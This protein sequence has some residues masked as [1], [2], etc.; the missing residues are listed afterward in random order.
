MENKKTNSLFA[1]MAYHFKMG[2]HETV[3]RHNC[4][5]RLFEKINHEIFMNDLLLKLEAE[6]YMVIIGGAD[7][8]KRYVTHFLIKYGDKKID[9]AKIKEWPLTHSKIEKIFKKRL[10]EINVIF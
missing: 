5:V 4:H 1:S 2:D 7:S 8:T 10:L 6:T 9:F 3:K